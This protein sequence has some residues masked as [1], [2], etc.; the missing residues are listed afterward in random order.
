M[1]NKIK[2]L[3]LLPIIIISFLIFKLISEADISLKSI[4]SFLYSCFSY[5]LWGAL[6]AYLFNPLMI[7]LDKLIASKK[8]SVKTK[9]AKRIC[10]ITFIY[11][12]FS[13]L[14]VLFG[15]AFIPEIMRATEVIL[16]KIPEYI[17][18]IE[19][20]SL[21]SFGKLN[22]NLES[23]VGD[24]LEKA[25]ELLYNFLKD[26]NFKLIGSRITAALSGSALALIRFFFGFGIS[27][28]LLYS[29]ES[30]LAEVKKLLFAVMPY[31]KARKISKISWSINDIFTSFV[32]SKLV[33]SMIM[34]II[35][36]FV[37]Y[38]LEVPLAAF[39]SFI[40]A[41]TNIIPYFGPYIG[42]IPSILITLL[43]DPVKALWVLIY[44]VGIQLLDNFIIGPKV[45][46]DRVGISPV[47][48]IAGV[49]LGG[50]IGGIFGMFI[51]VPV[52]AAIKLV[53][54]DS[55]IEKRLTA[56]NIDKDKL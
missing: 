47:L 34:F 29:K 28:Y 13:G 17:E 40:I 6:I 11:T 32:G 42:A 12:M 2:H 52:L 49:T 31:D 45:M 24:Y 35:G 19:S 55:F 27:A 21:R 54:Y 43:F 39:I 15:V 25:F 5:F 22:A 50:E 38:V 7:F 51:G 3:S 1:K 8:D 26:I 33:E 4:L 14:A 37:L 20:W 9:K 46:S 48:V 10:V 41:I 18:G 53:F 44:S 56:R 23:F 30:L 36:L 16:G